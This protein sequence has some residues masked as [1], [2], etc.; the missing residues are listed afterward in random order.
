MLLPRI[1]N[2]LIQWI[3]GW[4]YQTLYP[5]LPTKQSTFLLIS[6][7]YLQKTQL[8]SHKFNLQ[9]SQFQFLHNPHLKV[10]PPLIFFIHSELIFCIVVS[11]KN[12]FNF[13]YLIVS[14]ISGLNFL[15]HCFIF[16]LNT[17]GL[18]LHCSQRKIL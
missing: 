1:A 7:W 5:L 8:L 11:F 3:I 10:F 13:V 16:H 12:R 9:W 14:F 18:F 2:N 4:F 15:I 17:W 6:V